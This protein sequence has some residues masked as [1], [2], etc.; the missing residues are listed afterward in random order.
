MQ[1]KLL[2]G[3]YL[4]R[5]AFE[6]I[7]DEECKLRYG[8]PFVSSGSGFGVPKPYWL[9]RVLPNETT[10]DLEHGLGSLDVPGWAKIDFSRKLPRFHVL[11]ERTLA[12]SDEF[13]SR[14]G[15]L[16]EFDHPAAISYGS[17]DQD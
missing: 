15:L 2:N 6:N 10:G 11:T 17:E 9:D 1:E 8:A 5:T 13:P 16:D 3:R 4:D 14:E 12:G 7:T